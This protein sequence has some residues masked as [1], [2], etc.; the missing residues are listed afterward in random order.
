VSTLDQKPWECQTSEHSYQEK[1]QSILDSIANG[2]VYQVNLTA[3]HESSAVQP[4]ELYGQLLSAQQPSYGA[5]LEFEDVSIVSGSPE[6]FFEW[7]NDHLRTRPM[8]G[9]IRRGRF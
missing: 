6:L 3:M 2:D 5:L 4:S 1:V 8:K 7:R 9:T